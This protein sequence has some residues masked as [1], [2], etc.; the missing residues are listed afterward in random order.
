[1][2]NIKIEISEQEKDIIYNCLATFYIKN[3]DDWINEKA[4]TKKEYQ[5]LVKELTKKFI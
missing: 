4:I 2:E 1:M 3:L 5:E